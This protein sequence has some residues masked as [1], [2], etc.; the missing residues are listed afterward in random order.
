MCGAF[1]SGIIFTDLNALTMDQQNDY[2][3]GDA[4][5]VSD[6]QEEASVGGSP[7][8]GR[9]QG[10]RSR[11]WR[12]FTNKY[13]I[14]VLVFLVLLLFFD[15]NNLVSRYRVIR[16]LRQMDL[17]KQYFLDEIEINER[18]SDQLTHDLKEVEAYGRE[19]YLMKRPGEDIYLI[20]DEQER[21]FGE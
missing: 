4:E 2:L 5:P 15:T 7:S 11:T 3:L 10:K 13:L 16:E 12:L 14:T 6:R 18:I 19:K 21:P 20:I 9:E 17:Q 8:E 1:C